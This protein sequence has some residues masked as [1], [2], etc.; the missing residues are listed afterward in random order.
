MLFIVLFLQHKD[1]IMKEIESNDAISRTVDL[2][3]DTPEVKLFYFENQKLKISKD[4]KI[5]KEVPLT[6]FI[7]IDLKNVDPKTESE[8]EDLD[9]IKCKYDN[10]VEK[11]TELEK[12]IKNEK[13]NNEQL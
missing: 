7:W 8:L 2:L 5:I 1:I 13:E 9:D 11:Y 6:N 4:I 10:L 12:N 3:D